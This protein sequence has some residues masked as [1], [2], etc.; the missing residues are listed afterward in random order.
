MPSPNQDYGFRDKADID[1]SASGAGSVENDP[2]RAFRRFVA[3]AVGQRFKPLIKSEVSRSLQ[4]PPPKGSCARS[5]R[6]TVPSTELLS[7]YKAVGVR[8]NIPREVK[9]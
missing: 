3:A 5:V 8:K 4:N 9:K 7:Q 6:A 2:K 1:Y